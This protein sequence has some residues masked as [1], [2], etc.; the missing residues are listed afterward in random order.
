MIFERT[1][2]R[3]AATEP[4]RLHGRVKQAVGLV[5]QDFRSG[6]VAQWRQSDGVGGGKLA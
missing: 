2:E 3:L 1:R 6:A 5:V 4:A